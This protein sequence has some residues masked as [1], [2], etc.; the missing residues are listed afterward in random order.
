MSNIPRKGI[1][2]AAL[3]ENTVLPKVRVSSL[4]AEMCVSDGS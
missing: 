1:H 3:D 4:G 2:D